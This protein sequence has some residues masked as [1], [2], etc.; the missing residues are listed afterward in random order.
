MG[1]SNRGRPGRITKD[2]IN[3]FDFPIDAFEFDEYD[4]NSGGNQSLTMK[5]GWTLNPNAIESYSMS[6]K[7]I[8]APTT[9]TQID[10]G[11]AGDTSASTYDGGDSPATIVTENYNDNSGEKDV[12]GITSD[13]IIIE[14]PVYFKEGI[15]GT[16]ESLDFSSGLSGWQ[17]DEDGNVEFNTGT[18]RGDLEA[19][20]GTFSGD[21]ITDI[22]KVI[23]GSATAETAAWS[24]GYQ[25]INGYKNPYYD[26]KEVRNWF[27]SRGY[28]N[29]SE[30][31]ISSGTYM[32]T[33][34]SSVKMGYYIPADTSSRFGIYWV[35]FYDSGSSVIVPSSGPDSFYDIT[36]S[37]ADES[38]SRS[39]LLDSPKF[40]P[41]AIGYFPTYSWGQSDL[42]VNVVASGNIISATGLPSG[43]SGRDVGELFYVDNGDGTGTVKIKLED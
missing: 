18:F 13:A 43:S 35:N 15:V 17:I 21:F 29:D 42:Q 36:G 9:V 26:A 34:V 30:F 37:Y 16:M 19:A 27:L 3:P 33:S 40:W 25:T 28:P 31:T 38:G 22:F 39:L 32:E 8:T 11:T 24:G 10:G 23:E 2:D 12:S 14:S 6:V 7:H 20:G 41:K 1:F 4:K 5:D